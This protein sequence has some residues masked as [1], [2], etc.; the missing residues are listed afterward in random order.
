MME[1]MSSEEKHKLH[2]ANAVLDTQC[3]YCAPEIIEK[4]SKFK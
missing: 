2:K 3:E 1:P 4:E